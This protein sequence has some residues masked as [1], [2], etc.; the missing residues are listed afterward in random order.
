MIATVIDQKIRDGFSNA[1]LRYDILTY[2]YKE[3]GRRLTERIENVEL[4]RPLLDIGMGTG[5]FTR[6]LTT[7]FPD[8]LVVGVDS[9]PGM[10]SLARKR[11]GTFKIVQADASCLPFK[12]GSFDMITSN[13]AYQWIEDL[14]RAFALCCSRLSKRGGLYLTMFGH[15]TFHELFT[16]LDACAGKKSDNNGLAIRRLV[17]KGQVADALKNSGFNTMRVKT[18]HIKVHFPDMMN[19]IRWIKDIGANALSTDVYM[20]KNLLFRANQYYNI[21][22]KDPLGIYATFEVIWVEARR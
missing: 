7:V 21:H 22:F 20:G 17:D 2:F 5:W 16:V 14:P 4:L 6:R 1:A 3:I 10:V 11:E 19:L 12:E 8:I 18:E 15:D 13:L 9:A